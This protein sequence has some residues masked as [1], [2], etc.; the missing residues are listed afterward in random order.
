MGRVIVVAVHGTGADHTDRSIRL[1]GLHGPG[2]DTGSLGPQQEIIG[3][4]QVERILH[5][6]GRMILRQVQGFE[7]EVIVF[8]FRTAF[9]FKPHAHENLLD[10]PQ[11]ELYGMQ[12]AAVTM[13]AGQRDIDT[14]GSHLFLELTCLEK[15]HLFVQTGFDTGPHFV[16]HLAD[17]RP[18]LSGNGTEPAEDLRQGPFLSQIL[19]PDILQILD[20]LDFAKILAYFFTQFLQL[21]VH[22]NAS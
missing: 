17:L 9:H 7:I 1:A 16:D 10:F 2:L 4:C 21:I 19:D 11:R 15:L 5:I 14:L 8:D 3:R 12:M 13:T 22:T 20:I 18:F 6:P